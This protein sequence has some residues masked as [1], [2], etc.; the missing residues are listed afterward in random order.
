MDF[1][2]YQL[3]NKSTF[4]RNGKKFKSCFPVQSISF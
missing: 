3:S 2:K 1:K 4:K